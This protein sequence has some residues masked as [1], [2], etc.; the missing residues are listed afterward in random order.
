MKRQKSKVAQRTQKITLRIPYNLYHAI[1][2]YQQNQEIPS[3]LNH[4]IL[5]LLVKGF[6]HIEHA[7]ISK[8]K[9]TS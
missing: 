8:Q 7:E 6:E 9:E 5:D 1:K 2:L 4:C 3:S